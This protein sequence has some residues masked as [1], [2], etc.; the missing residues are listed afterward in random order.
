MNIIE[1]DNFKAVIDYGHNMGA[2]KATGELLPHLAPGRKIRMASGTGNRR[3]ED[4]EEYGFTLSKYYDHVVVTDTDRRGRA[5]GVVAEWVC[6]GLRRG[7]F[8]E[9]QISVVLDGRE[10]T[11]AA[12]EMAEKGDIVVLQADDVQLV[13][14][15]VI[16]MAE[17]GDIVV[18]QAED[19]QLVIQDV[20]DYKENIKRTFLKQCE[21]AAEDVKTR[22][23]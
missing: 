5:P 23:D 17:K 3:V 22:E 20:M 15:D 14:Q 11:K 10:A 2:I 19:V 13:I 4:V 6:R 16:E 9:D 1:V 21:E 12:L 7:G 8:K 18:L